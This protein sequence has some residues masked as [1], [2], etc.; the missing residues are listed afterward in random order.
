M[1]RILTALLVCLAGSAQAEWVHDGLVEPGIFA[2]HT[3]QAQRV[4]INRYDNA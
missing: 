4:L 3:W 2:S 1:K